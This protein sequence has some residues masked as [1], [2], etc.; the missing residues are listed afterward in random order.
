MNRLI[1]R[2]GLRTALAALVVLVLLALAAW[3]NAPLVARLF[4]GGADRVAALPASSP[5][6]RGQRV[7]LLSPHPDDETLCCAGIIQQAQAAGAQVF[8]AWMTAGDG[9][10]FDAVL[11]QRVADPSPLDMQ[12]L[13]N[14][15]AAEAR[16]AVA[17][18]GV[19]PA[20]T[21]MLGY[22]DGGLFQLF[23]TH[24]QDPYLAPHTGTAA[25][26]VNGAL[27]PNAPFTGQAWEADLNRVL[28][29]VQPHLVLAPAPQDFHSDH[30]TLSYVALRLMAARQ[31]EDR[32]R[33]WVVHGGLEW[34][35]P[36]GLHPELSLTV[37]PL[38]STLPWTRVTLSAAQRQRKLDAVNAYHTQTRVMGRFMRAFVR[39]NELLSPAPLP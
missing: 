4:D 26:Y 24:Y 2:S 11:T 6:I 13:G 38:A 9:F 1:R 35:L 14:A 12:A 20:R 8:V 15:R 36:K 18:L 27:T 23:T 39:Q 34:P 10:E 32:L 16:R 21:F 31:Q 28:A 7:L 19:P 30:R 17:L 3:I 25:V 29:R 22:P 37:P 5:F 33:F